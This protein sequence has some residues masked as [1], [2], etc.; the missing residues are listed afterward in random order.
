MI[1]VSSLI[2]MDCVN[3]VAAPVK[4]VMTL[5]NARHARLDS[6]R[7]IQYVFSVRLMNSFLE[8]PALPVVPTVL[9]ALQDLTSA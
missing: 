5:Q 2:P 3:H 4:H 1:L 7:V 9:G 8:T 6:K